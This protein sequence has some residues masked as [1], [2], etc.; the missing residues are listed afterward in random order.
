MSIAQTISHDCFRCRGET[1]GG[2]L[3]AIARIGSA[4]DR[5]MLTPILNV[6]NRQLPKIIVAFL[7]NRYPS[8]QRA[9][10]KAK[11]IICE[12]FGL[13]SIARIMV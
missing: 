2:I 5:R 11:R 6:W 9:S 4:D 7:L 1:D 3:D 10:A 13:Q 8:E 12:L